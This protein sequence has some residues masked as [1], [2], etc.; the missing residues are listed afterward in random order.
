[1]RYNERFYT[2]VSSERQYPAYDVEASI[3]SG[4]GVEGAW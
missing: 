3:L 1:M 2:N 4:D